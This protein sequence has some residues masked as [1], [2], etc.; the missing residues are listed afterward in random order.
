VGTVD[1]ALLDRP[2]AA[3][4]AVKQLQ[5]ARS[6]VVH[7]YGEY[8]GTNPGGA[9]ALLGDATWWSD[10]GVEVEAV[11]RY[12]PASPSAGAGYAGW[13]AA[14]AARLAAVRHVVAIQIGNE[15]NATGSAAASDGAYPG[16][17]GA[18]ATA[19]PA[20][21]AAVLTA[22][23]PDVAIGFNWA[24][25]ANPCALDPYFAALERAGGQGFVGAVGWVGV[26]VYPGTWSAP[27][28]TPDP[29]P[30]AI[31][32]SMTS[33]LG[34]LR[35][36][37]MPSAGLPATVPITVA[38]T[39]YPTD[40]ARSEASQTVV[41]R[42]IVGAIRA[43]AATDGVTDLRWFGLRDA[44]TGSGQLENGYGLLRDDYSSKPAF[45]TYQELVAA[46]GR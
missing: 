7:L 22:G 14:V 8:S 24:A 42:A 38:E 4:A 35:G 29:S 18:I 19:L 28:A 10:H 23:R 40:A 46:D 16:V 30:D 41:L 32:A 15:G 33:A 34:C 13:V 3:L 45:A 37:Q 5:G 44:N 21:R 36:R 26:D 25:G 31:A 27:T 6:F 39:G 43:V 17:T 20:A 11:L 2:D 1:P 12:R 9:D